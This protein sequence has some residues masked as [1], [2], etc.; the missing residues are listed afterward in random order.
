MEKNI[1]FIKNMVCRSCKIVINDCLTR[2]DIPVEKI[3]LGKVTLKRPLNKKEKKSLQDDLVK[4]GFSILDGKNE[5]IASSVKS[6]IIKGIYKSKRFGNRN[7]SAV[8]CEKLNY[9]YSYISNIFTKTEGKSIQDFQ[10]EMKIKRVKE[11]LEYDELSISEIAQELGYSSAAYLSTQFRK[12]TGEKPS[13]YKL[14]HS[15]EGIK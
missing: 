2:L 10:L 5:R 1:L 6:I 13:Q 15:G 4:N 3:S 9:D 12:A 11:L 7:L 8:L 14:R